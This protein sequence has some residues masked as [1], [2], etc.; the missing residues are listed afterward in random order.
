MAVP[1]ACRPCG[2]MRRIHS[3]PS[4]TMH[5]SLFI[6]TGFWLLVAGSLL[7]PALVF[8]LMLWKRAISRPMVLLFGIVLIGLAGIDVVLLQ[9]L[10]TWARGTPSTLDNRIFTSEVSAALYLLPVVLGGI[11]VN[12]VSHVL[13]HHL[14]AA[15]QRFDTQRAPPDGG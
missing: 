11:G 15:E 12:L 6:E 5:D 13:I 3:L 14:S 1:L 4:T 9:W 7:A 2:K 10:G 8:G